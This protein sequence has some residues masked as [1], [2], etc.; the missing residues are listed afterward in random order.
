MSLGGEEAWSKWQFIVAVRK[1]FLWD[2]SITCYLL[3]L[4]KIAVNFA[5]YSG[6]CMETVI[7]PAATS[8]VG[9]KC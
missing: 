8:Q 6:K 9:N 7:K 5:L 2:L 4:P 3:L 1:C